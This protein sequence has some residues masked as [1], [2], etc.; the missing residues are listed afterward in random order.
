[1]FTP[2][3]V[4]VSTQGGVIHEVPQPPARPVR[5]APTATPN[6]GTEPNRM[7]Q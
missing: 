2:S 1:L 3:C 4:Q 7:A 6:W 5:T